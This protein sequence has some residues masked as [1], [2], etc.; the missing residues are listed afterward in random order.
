[1]Y[2]WD[3]DE[4]P[5]RGRTV[6]IGAT[7]VALAALGWFVVR[8]ALTD[9]EAPAT[10]QSLAFEDAESTHQAV[11]PSASRR[12]SRR[13][14]RTPRR[15]QAHRCDDQ[16]IDCRTPAATSDVGHQRIVHVGLPSTDLAD[17]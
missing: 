10:E 3:D 13:P 11:S 14:L 15:R 6:V 2:E 16:R 8:P 7:V 17:D 1:M 9:D 5:S 12:V 4:G